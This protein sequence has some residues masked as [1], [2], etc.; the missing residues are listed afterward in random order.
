MARPGEVKMYLQSVPEGESSL[1][2]VPIKTETYRAQRPESSA[3]LMVDN[4]MEIRLGGPYNPD[5]A[6]GS[7][8]APLM[9]TWG[10]NGA[11][12]LWL[13]LQKMGFASGCLVNLRLSGQLMGFPDF[14]AASC[15]ERNDKVCKM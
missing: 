2:A 15:G 5:A 3:P 12:L 7:G 11:E 4:Q 9:E 1:S 10:D 8:D 6:S 13:K 14:A